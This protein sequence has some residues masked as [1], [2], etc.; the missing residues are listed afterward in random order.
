MASHWI[1]KYFDKQRSSWSIQGLQGAQGLVAVKQEQIISPPPQEK[2]FS[3]KTP[4]LFSFFLILLSW[5]LTFNM[6]TEACRVEDVEAEGEALGGFA[7][8][9]R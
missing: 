2:K 4:I 1:V 9:L 8:S 7:V 5:N 6:L 3:W